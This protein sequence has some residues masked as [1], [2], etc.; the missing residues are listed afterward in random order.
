MGRPPYGESIWKMGKNKWQTRRQRE[1]CLFLLR[2]PPSAKVSAH[3]ILCSFRTNSF[4]VNIYTHHNLQ[5]NSTGVSSQLANG[6]VTQQCC[7]E[8]VYLRTVQQWNKAPHAI[9]SSQDLW[10]R[11]QT[12]W[13]K[14]IYFA[15][16]GA[17]LV[18]NPPQ[19]QFKS[20]FQWECGRRHGNNIIR[21]QLQK[22]QQIQ[23][24]KCACVHISLFLN[25]N[26]WAK[27]VIVYSY[28]QHVTALHFFHWIW[29]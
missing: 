27:R 19:H 9:D 22:P 29:S 17:Q 3:F 1:E 2:V 5:R 26:C 13:K 18:G 6:S 28:C 20:R 8:L 10:D 12:W 15:E 4:K 23:L 24:I 14:Y 16:F 21:L 11:A 25:K 7:A